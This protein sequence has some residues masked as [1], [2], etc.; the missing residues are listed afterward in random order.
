MPL[1]F[2]DTQLPLFLLLLVLKFNDRIHLAQT[3]GQVSNLTQHKRFSHWNFFLLHMFGDLFH[4]LS[5]RWQSTLW[6]STLI[7]SGLNKNY[8]NTL[9]SWSCFRYVIKV[10]LGLIGRHLTGR[11]TSNIFSN[12]IKY[13]LQHMITSR[14][15]VI[16]LALTLG[17]RQA[18]SLQLWD[19]QYPILYPSSWLSCQISFLVSDR[20]G[21]GWAYWSQYRLLSR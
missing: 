4:N 20:K 5:S 16:P 13:A 17:Q 19:E 21:F 9:Q 10:T 8:Y 6:P 15:Q 11:R 12:I 3:R 18:T 14:K 1:H 7:M 2:K